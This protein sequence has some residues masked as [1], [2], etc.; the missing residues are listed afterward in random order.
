[1]F[2]GIRYFVMNRRGLL[3]NTITVI[4]GIALEMEAVAAVKQDVGSS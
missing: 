3:R 4:G 2:D 1:L